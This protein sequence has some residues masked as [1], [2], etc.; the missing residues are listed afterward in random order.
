MI[1][2]SKDYFFRRLVGWSF[3]LVQ[4]L[5]IGAYI[6]DFIAQFHDNMKATKGLILQQ[7]LKP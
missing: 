7:K 3:Q 5:Y 2:L 4:R 1:V 6:V